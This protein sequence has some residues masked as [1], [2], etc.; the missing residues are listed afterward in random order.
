MPGPRSAEVR[1]PG[2]LPVPVRAKAV[3]GR[4]QARRRLRWVRLGPGYPQTTGKFPA[5]AAGP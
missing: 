2:S 4:P 1:Q 3:T 5:T